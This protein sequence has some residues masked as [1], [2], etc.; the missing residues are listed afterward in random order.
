MRNNIINV[1][2]GLIIQ[3]QKLL[4]CQRTK[5]KDHGL[6][7]EFPGGKIEDKETKETALT[8]ETV[9]YTHLTLPTKA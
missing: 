4:I 2:G 3:N 7:W 6:K 1:V 5:N 8:R 9:S